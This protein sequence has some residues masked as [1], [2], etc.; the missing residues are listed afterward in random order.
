MNLF[1]EGS[2]PVRC[3]R[4]F[5]WR[6]P[7]CPPTPLR[8][9]NDLG[10][11]WQNFCHRNRSIFLSRRPPFSCRD[12]FWTFRKAKD[13]NLHHSLMLPVCE[14]PFCVFWTDLCCSSDSCF[15]N[16]FLTKFKWL[17]LL[18]NG[19]LWSNARPPLLNRNLML[20]DKNLP[21]NVGY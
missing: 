15:Y 18:E 13:W 1:L 9:W 7:P 12:I 19:F 14:S 6:P 2:L 5:C 10:S 11:R 3:P 8:N 20:F 16:N 4:Q 21:V 17:N